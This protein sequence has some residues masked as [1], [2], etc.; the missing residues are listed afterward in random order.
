MSQTETQTKVNYSNGIIYK[1]CCRDLEIKEEYIGST[2]SFTKRKTQ[3]KSIC[4]N[5]NSN[6][7]NYPVYV[8][9]RQNGGWNNWDMV[10]VEKYKATDKHDLHKRERYWMETSKSSLNK[11][12]PSH[13]KK[14][15]QKI[16]RINNKE[17]VLDGQ[18]N[19]RI[20]NKEKV[21]EYQ[22][23]YLEKNKDR[24]L[25]RDKEK[26]IC[27]CGRMIRKRDK[28]THLKTKIHKKTLG[29]L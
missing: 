28:S 25:E 12:I 15:Y 11:R 26:I 5:E 16:Y 13:I 7:Y 4:A 19:Y 22:K 6:M 20:N 8:C 21:L 14:E 18:K 24:I 23:N 1:L 9:I 3:H 27:E 2:T 17:K 10:E 29:I